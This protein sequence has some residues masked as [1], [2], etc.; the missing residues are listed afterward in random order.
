[1]IADTD[2]RRRTVLEMPPE[3]A[4][5]FFLK[6]DSYCSVELPPYFSF[7][8]ILTQ[9]AE[10]LRSKTSRE[11]S[12]EK[13][14]KDCEG[15]NYSLLS[16]KDGRHAWRPFELIHPI[17]YCDSVNQITAENNWDDIVKR[18]QEFA[19]QPSIQ[20][21]SI[22]VESLSDQD[23]IEEQILKWWYEI[24]QRSIRLALEYEVI[25][26]TDI[27]DCYGQIY[28]HSIAWALHR[29]EVAKKPENRGNSSLIGNSID[30]IIQD[31]RYGQTN[32]I[33]QGSVLADFIAEMVLGYAD[34][35]LSEK[36]SNINNISDYQII[37]YRDDYRIFV[38]ST[39]DAEKIL[40]ELTQ[41]LFEL[42]LR[43]NSAKTV[44]SEEVIRASIKKDK[45]NWL[46][47]KQSGRTLQEQLLIIHDHANY[48]PNSGSLMRGLT[49]FRRKLDKDKQGDLEPATATVLIS[50]IIDIAFNNPRT[51][52]V[53]AAILSRLLVSIPTE[54]KIKDI[55]EKIVRKFQRIP[56]TGYLDIWLQRIA[57]PLG[58]DFPFN[59]P[60]C[61]IASKNKT[62][63][64]WNNEW[65]NAKDLQRI[66]ATSV[67]DEKEL[68][69]IKQKPIIAPEEVELFLKHYPV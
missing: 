7:D 48:N 50:I 30:R 68:E 35:L 28:T 59:E 10:Y 14:P 55:L 20:C 56:N 52:P 26:L 43:L 13:K 64:L 31:M 54:D 29:K 46:S 32:G 22:P 53:C 34:T 60:L 57:L 12:T 6:P 45:L 61:K 8:S 16:N 62:D 15:V 18:F 42:G 21:M 25:A 24:E 41:V 2:R 17:L 4:R 5:T 63:S 67:L 33:P 1:M 40:K 65:V 3:E 39:S 69:E 27:V 44:I 38:H 47:R 11:I 9:T 37:R 51:Y 49:M 36:L 58:L 23:D 19:S 66:M